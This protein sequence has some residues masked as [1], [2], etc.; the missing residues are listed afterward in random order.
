M[1][2]LRG[3]ERSLFQSMLYQLSNDLL[4]AG[5]V[6]IGQPLTD[7]RGLGDIGHCC[8]LPF[9]GQGAF[10]SFENIEALGVLRTLLLMNCRWHGGPVK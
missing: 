8:C 5:E 9:A 10:G 3:R 2:G 4:F 7:A 6:A 1:W